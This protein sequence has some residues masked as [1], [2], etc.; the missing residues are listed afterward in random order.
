V[1]EV[2]PPPASGYDPVRREQARRLSEAMGVLTEK[3]RQALVLID[4]E[5]FSSREAAQV[6][7]CLAIT[8]RTRAA[9]AR[10]KL[11]RELARYYPELKEDV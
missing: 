10:K 7:G 4:L 5:G 2:E 11:R 3:E 8:A 9:Q 1:G 6:L